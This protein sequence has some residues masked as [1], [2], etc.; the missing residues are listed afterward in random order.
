MAR[1]NAHCRKD[2]VNFFLERGIASPSGSN[3]E[4]SKA[5]L[6]RMTQRFLKGNDFKRGIRKGVMSYEDRVKL[7]GKR[8]DHVALILDIRTLPEH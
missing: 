4:R 8:E 2:L 5:S 3:V 1:R 6:L 7:N